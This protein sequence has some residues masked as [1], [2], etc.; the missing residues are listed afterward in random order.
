MDSK[1][2][3]GRGLKF[4][5]G[6]DPKTGKIAMVEFEDDIREAIGIIIRTSRGERVMLPDFGTDAEDYT[7]S[8]TGSGIGDTIVHDLTR[9]L[10]LQEPRIQ[11][12]SVS[13]DSGTS[14]GQ[15]LISVGYTVRSTNNRYNMVYPFYISEGSKIEP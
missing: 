3:L 6:I 5:L 15:L 12:I 4:P 7:F 14:D 9:D 1:S 11:D 13:C 2:F 10:Q 8:P